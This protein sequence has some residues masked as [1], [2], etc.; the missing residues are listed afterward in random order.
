MDTCLNDALKLD[1]LT[2]VLSGE[3]RIRFEKHL[4]ACQ[5][6]RGEIIELRRTAA[7]VA[8]L[9]LPG[10]PEAWTA[11]AKDRLREKESSLVS[12]VPARPAPGP[13]K[14]DVFQYGLIAG[15]VTATVVLLLWLVMG[16]AFKDWFPGLSAA[17]LGISDHRAARTVGLVTWILSLHAL[18]LVPSI[19]D[20]IYQ[21]VQKGGRR[22][23]PESSTGSP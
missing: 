1:Y 20:D 8:S 4:K 18:L 19:I 3:D 12:A 6:C 9:A 21:L 13:R 22:T 11:T 7:A 10:V 16:G 2:G 15:G 17:A 5:A 23:R 14:T